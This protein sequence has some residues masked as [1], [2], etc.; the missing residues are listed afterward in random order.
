MQ[1]RIKDRLTN[2]LLGQSPMPSPSF[3][4]DTLRCHNG[5]GAS[6]SVAFGCQRVCFRE[7]GSPDFWLLLS[8]EFMTSVYPHFG[9]ISVLEGELM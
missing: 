3:N 6:A 1:Y 8:L 5:S 2:V 9:F 7:W 4:T